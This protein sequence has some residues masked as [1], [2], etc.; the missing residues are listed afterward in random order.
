MAKGLRR[1]DEEPHCAEWELP[2]D[3][4]GATRASPLVAEVLLA[5]PSP[6][7]PE[8]V[9]VRLKAY[10]RDGSV[11][12]YA[13][14]PAGTRAKYCLWIGPERP[15]LRVK[16]NRWSEA[17]TWWG[18][19][20]FGKAG[21]HCGRDGLLR[22][23]V[24]LLVV[25]GAAGP[26]ALPDS[27][28]LGRELAAGSFGAVREATYAEA[29]R[30]DGSALSG[31]SG[32]SA[33]SLGCGAELVAKLATR[34]E[35]ALDFAAEAQVMRRLEGPGFGRLL[36]LFRSER[37]GHSEE[38]LVMERLHRT[39]QSLREDESVGPRGR[40]SPETVVEVGYQLI[41]RLQ[42]MHELGFVHM[43]LKPENIMIGPG[44]GDVIYLIDFGLS[45]HYRVM[46]MHLPQK[47]GSL[48]GT[49]RYCSVH[50]H[51]SFSSRRADIESLGL[52]LIFLAAA[53]LPWQEC[54]GATKQERYKK[55]L[56]RKLEPGLLQ[57]HTRSRLESHPRLANALVSMVERS[58][59]L[60]FEDEPDYAWFKS[61]LV[62]SLQPELRDIWPGLACSR[63]DFPVRKLDWVT[64]DSGQP[65][66]VSGSACLQI[67]AATTKEPALVGSPLLMGNGSEPVSPNA[68]MAG[69]CDTTPNVAP[70]SRTPA[71]TPPTP[72][73]R[74]GDNPA[75]KSCTAPVP[76][77]SGIQG[78]RSHVSV[79]PP[80]ASRSAQGVSKAA[81][82][83]SRLAAHR[84]AAPST[85]G[86]SGGPSGP[87]ERGRWRA[88]QPAQS[89][90][91]LGFGLGSRPMSSGYTQILSGAKTSIFTL[92]ELVNPEIWRARGVNPTERE[93]HL[94][95]AEFIEVFGVQRFEFYRLPKWKR[96]AEKRKR[97]LF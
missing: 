41:D 89:G 16:T 58:R 48:R 49:A 33:C 22:L 52:L 87:A 53:H 54:D 79:I 76:V 81:S 5:L 77:A 78:Q 14:L 46:G 27:I 57:S 38:L 3:L 12:Y 21:E 51:L 63:S 23:G 6:P 15:Q 75:A 65:L 18:R 45:R 28:H 55:I 91:P 9:P 93:Q 10:I 74:L 72:P 4:F 47:E 13:A 90:Y 7:G 73:V 64:D 94:C 26:P 24:A 35:A 85:A 42:R 82:P 61:N 88:G 67:T 60:E 11:C 92:S 25:V 70:S 29:D 86:P 36:G 50:A 56:Q 69:T 17:D 32:S 44:K 31:V 40:L 39:L 68:V 34:E 80:S 30:S 19:S 1:S 43:D 2:R 96:D 84:P 71:R 97:G 83:T 8:E 20:A 66:Q 62:S 59:A 95:D 37:N